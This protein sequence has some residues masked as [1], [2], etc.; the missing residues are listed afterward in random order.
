LRLYHF[1]ARWYDPAT[2]GFVSRDPLGWKQGPNRYSSQFAL[3]GIDPSGK[4]VIRDDPQ[5]IPWETYL[6]NLKNGNQHITCPVKWNWIERTMSLGCIGV[7]SIH[8]GW[9]LD[10]SPDRRRFFE[11][12]ADAEAE[13]TNLKC[14]KGTPALFS[15]HYWSGGSTFARRPDGTV[16][17]ENWWN[18][19]SPRCR[20]DWDRNGNGVMDDE[21]ITRDRNGN[22]RIDPDEVRSGVNFDFGYFCPDHCAMFHG[23]HYYNPDPDGDGIGK[24]F[25]PGTEVKNDADVK[26]SSCERWQRSY[27]D[28]DGEVWCVTCRTDCFQNYD[29]SS[30]FLPTDPP[31]IPAPS[32]PAPS[33][34]APSIPGPSIPGPSIPRGNPRSDS[35]I[36]PGIRRIGN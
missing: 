7:T 29:S 17:M 35:T 25:P 15:I 8:L 32:I 20:P 27:S 26:V 21:E 11:K 9:M 30:P 12:R 13:M 18:N 14:G 5:S 4:M 19:G 10:G 6:G 16:D 31:S 34:P 3:R 36:I 28:F 23:D 2:G 24:Y 33:I 22:G 1:R